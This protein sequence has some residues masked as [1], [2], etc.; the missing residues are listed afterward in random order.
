M[1]KRHVHVVLKGTK[2]LSNVHTIKKLCYILCKL[3]RVLIISQLAY[4]SKLQQ[5]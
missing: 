2:S 4:E 1:E 3:H 5:I